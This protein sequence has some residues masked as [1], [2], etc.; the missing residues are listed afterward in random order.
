MTIS[1]HDMQNW[2]PA[3]QEQ[4]RAIADGHIEGVAFIKPRIAQAYLD[5]GDLAA[6]EK[7]T[8]DA[9]WRGTGILFNGKRVKPEEFFLLPGEIAHGIKQAKRP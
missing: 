1:A 6:R 5:A 9:G 8:A 2:E 7:A 3:E 4:W